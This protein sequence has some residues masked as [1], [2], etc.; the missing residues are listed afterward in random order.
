ML[1]MLRQHAATRELRLSDV[2]RRAGMS[3]GA[4]RQLLGIGTR[5]TKG[6]HLLPLER[7]IQALGLV[8]ELRKAQGEVV[9]K[10]KPLTLDEYARLS[11]VSITI[12]PVRRP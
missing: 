3:L 4:V 9:G 8:W 11:G 10:G 7:L 5:T 6:A 1:E 2:A 12:T